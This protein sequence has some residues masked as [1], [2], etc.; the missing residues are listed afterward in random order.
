MYEHVSATAVLSVL[1][2]PAGLT[3][4]DLFSQRGEDNADVEPFIRVTT[5]S[6]FSGGKV[7]N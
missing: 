6:S 3:H 7:G 4:N 5:S 1:L 2:P